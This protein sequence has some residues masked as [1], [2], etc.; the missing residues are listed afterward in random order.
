M[1]QGHHLQLSL[2]LAFFCNFRL[3]N[4]KAAAAHHPIIQNEV[5]DLL[6]KGTT[7]PSSGGAGYCSSV[8][9][10]PKHTGG[11]WLILNLQQFNHYLNIPSFTMPTIKHVRQLIRHVDY[12]FFIDLQDAYLHIPFVKHHCHF[13]QF[14]WHSVPYQWEVLPFWLAA[15][16]R[17]FIALTKPILFL[18]HHKGFCV[19][20]LDDILVLVCSK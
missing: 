9:V 7:E 15:G 2:C 11:V 10:V 20:C 4:G 3:F 19:I 13:L 17:I 8:F 1:V 14:V 5:D 6:A 18:C 16:P 12:A